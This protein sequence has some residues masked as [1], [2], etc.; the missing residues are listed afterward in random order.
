MAVRDEAEFIDFVQGSA[1][2][3]RRMAFLM[4]GDWH[5][6]QDVVQQAYVRLYVAWPKLRRAEAFDSYA[7]RTVLSVLRD[8]MRRPWWRRERTRG[9]LPET[10]TIDAHAAVDNQLHVVE[11]LKSL[12]ER[13]RAVLVLRYLEDLTVEQTA[14]VLGIAPGTV[15]SQASR[16]L[17]TLRQQIAPE[18]TT[19]GITA[20]RGRFDDQA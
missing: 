12:P 1:A 18:T 17:T 5:R 15:K 13:Q 20:E 9:D 7:R 6:A 16:G 19:P 10:A 8:D 2:R 14:E 11:L 3:L 4:C